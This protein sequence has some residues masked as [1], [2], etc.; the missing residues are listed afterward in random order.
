MA[1]LNL[2]S[3]IAFFGL[4]Y[5]LG[6]VNLS[7]MEILFILMFCDLPMQSNCNITPPLPAGTSDFM[8]QMI[9]WCVSFA[10]RSLPGEPFPVRMPE[11]A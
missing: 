9:I 7:S 3:L 8:Y 4:G 1:K 2:F 10:L 11:A 6:L 5:A